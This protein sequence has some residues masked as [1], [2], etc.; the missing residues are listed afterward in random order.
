MLNLKEANLADAEKEFKLISHLP[1]NENGFTNEDFGCS[2][3]AFDKI[4]LPGYINMSKGI[5]LP[6]GWV[7]VTTFFLWNDDQIVGLFRVRH[8][9]NEYLENG[10]GHIGYAIDTPFRRKGYATRGLSLAIEQAKKIIRENEIYMSVAKSNEASLKVQIR[11]G[12]YI[13]HMDNNEYYTR[14]LLR[15]RL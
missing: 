6:A 13:H 7:P 4:I 11:N 2:R 8:H 14:I 15:N 12:A 5:D 3:M 9:L 1:K 10:P